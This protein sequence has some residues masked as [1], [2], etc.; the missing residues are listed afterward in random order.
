MLKDY[1]L[2]PL[3]DSAITGRKRWSDCIRV[4]LLLKIVSDLKLRPD[5]ILLYLNYTESN[6]LSK[7]LFSETP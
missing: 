7:P 3:M 2:Q 5:E 6:Q 1:F 4:I